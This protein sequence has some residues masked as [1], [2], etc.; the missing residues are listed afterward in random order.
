MP[1]LTVGSPFKLRARIRASARIFAD[2]VGIPDDILLSGIAALYLAQRPWFFP[3]SE[4][5]RPCRAVWTIFRR[6]TGRARRAP[7]SLR[8]LVEMDRP[9]GPYRDRICSGDNRRVARLG[10]L[11]RDF[12]K[13]TR[14]ELTDQASPSGRCRRLDASGSRA[15]KGWRKTSAYMKAGVRHP[16]GGEWRSPGVVTTS[17]CRPPRFVTLN[18]SRAL[19]RSD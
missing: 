18:H 3:A 5:G 8:A 12:P 9:R 10:S 2:Y 16:C 14:L 7:C 6:P 11:R 15:V 19:P 1:A 13:V 17:A 4:S